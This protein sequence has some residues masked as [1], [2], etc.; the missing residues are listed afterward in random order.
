MEGCGDKCDAWHGHRFGAVTEP[1]R[2][3]LLSR[4]HYSLAAGAS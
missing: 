2:R 1:R 3:W 4:L